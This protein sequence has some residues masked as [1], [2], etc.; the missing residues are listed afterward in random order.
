MLLQIKK[1]LVTLTNENDHNDDHED[2]YKEMFD[3]M[4]R[5]K[6]DGI[7]ELNNEINHNYLTY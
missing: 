6:F 4:V 1:R 5:E 2:I 7:G 3:K